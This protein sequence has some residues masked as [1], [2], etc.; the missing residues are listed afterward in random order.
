MTPETLP[1]P[2]QGPIAAGVADLR[3]LYRR[4]GLR[5][6]LRKFFARLRAALYSREEVVVLRK[7]LREAT[8][9]EFSESLRVGELEAGDLPAL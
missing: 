3:C 8:E 7:D 4:H 6:L 5:E 2:Q 1:S 9:M